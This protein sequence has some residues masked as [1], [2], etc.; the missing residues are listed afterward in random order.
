MLRAGWGNTKG[1]GVTS[2]SGLAQVSQSQIPNGDADLQAAGR[3][4][5]V[6]GQPE[7]VGR[8]AGKDGNFAPHLQ[9]PRPRP[10]PSD[11]SPWHRSLPSQLQEGDLRKSQSGLTARMGQRAEFS[12]KS[13]RI[14]SEALHSVQADWECWA[15]LAHFPPL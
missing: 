6:G 7:L 9:P 5:Q 1:G 14:R 3:S 12:V 2:A 11:F 15:S 4:G 8:G 10:D 13:G